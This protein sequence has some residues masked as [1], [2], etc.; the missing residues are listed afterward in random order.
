MKNRVSLIC[1]IPYTQHTEHTERNI[2][3]LQCSSFMYNKRSEYFNF[4]ILYARIE[5][6]RGTFILFRWKGLLLFVN[7]K[8]WVIS[9][10]NFSKRFLIFYF[11]SLEEI[12]FGNTFWLLSGYFPFT[13]SNFQQ[14][15]TFPFS[16]VF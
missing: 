10:Y 1:C 5:L 13:E 6:N 4:C 3:S 9:E 14:I 12:C 15:E 16:H 8:L 2:Y 7:R 11:Q